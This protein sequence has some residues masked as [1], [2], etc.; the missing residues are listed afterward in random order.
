MGFL[1]LQALENPLYSFDAKGVLVGTVVQVV[2]LI[3]IIAVS[4]LK[5]W[6]RRTAKAQEQTNSES[7]I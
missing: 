2:S 3:M 6:G 5:P 1:H 7:T 4:L